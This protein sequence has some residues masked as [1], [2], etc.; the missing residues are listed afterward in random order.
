[1]FPSPLPKGRGVRFPD[2]FR[3]DNNY[4]DAQ[5]KPMSLSFLKTPKCILFLAA[6]ALAAGCAT[7]RG[8]APTPEQ[9]AAKEQRRA[10]DQ[11]RRA[12]EREANE[13]RRAV[14]ERRGAEEGLRRQF[15][16][17]STGELK[18][19]DAR[20]KDLRVGSGRDLNVKVNALGSSNLDNKNIE[21]LLEIER[22]LLRRWK[23]GDSEAYL[24]DFQAI[25][26]PGKK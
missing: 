19:M 13:Q 10:A 1:M 18:L 3:I 26:P 22:E 14:A 7:F 12:E 16:R 9:Q 2:E 15:A 11:K 23:A 17:Y 20:Y 21:R 8:P 5:V 24:P 6:V 4:A 25:S